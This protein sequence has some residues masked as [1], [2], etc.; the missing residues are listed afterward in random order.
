V[1][2]LTAEECNTALFKVAKELQD[3]S[4]EL[5]LD[6]AVGGG[7]AVHIL[8]A[9]VGKEPTEWKHKDI[10]LVLPFKQISEFIGLIKSLGY[11]KSALSPRE[12]KYFV[13]QNQISGKKVSIN[14]AGAISATTIMVEYKGYDYKILSAD[15]LLKSIKEKWIALNKNIKIE[16]SVRFLEEYVKSQSESNRT[17]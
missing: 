5:G 8:E 7:L 12:E 6:V 11:I 3:K 14:F 13:Y 10:D 16:R 15:A 1:N 9:S 4:E 17:M 2:Y